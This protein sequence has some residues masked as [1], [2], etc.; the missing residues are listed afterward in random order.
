MYFIFSSV[1]EI[2]CCDGVFDNKISKNTLNFLRTFFKHFCRYKYNQNFFPLF[3]K[4]NTS[5]VYSG[6]SCVWLNISKTELRSIKK[7]VLTQNFN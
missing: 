7:K 5:L 4:L 2:I 6:G 3:L 1:G